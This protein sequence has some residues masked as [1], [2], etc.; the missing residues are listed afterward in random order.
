MGARLGR[1]G[2]VD[3]VEGFGEEEGFGEVCEGSWRGGDGGDV[4]EGREEVS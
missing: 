3:W 4:S 2:G 1:E